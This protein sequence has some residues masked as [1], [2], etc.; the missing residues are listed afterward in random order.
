MV[1]DRP[2][3]ALDNLTR[4]CLLD[5]VQERSRSLNKKALIH[6]MLV[7]GRLVQAQQCQQELADF[8]DQL[9]KKYSGPLQIEAVSGLFLIYASHFVHLLEGPEQALMEFLTSLSDIEKQEDMVGSSKVV[10]IVNDVPT[11]LFSLWNY[12]CV[13]IA[14]LRM[15]ES[16]VQ[17]SVQ[18]KISDSMVLMMK[19][20]QE[21]AKVP[22]LQQKGVLD[23]LVSKHSHLLIHSDLVESLLKST[24]LL[25][26]D[27]YVKMYTKP[28]HVTLDN[29][30][31]WPVKGKPEVL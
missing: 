16:K 8:F 22:K 31:V 5:V 15:D 9:V 14:S 27:E 13:N 7:V 2:D 20:S 23:Q 4:V 19:L 1:D 11:R 10:L 26:A 18:S 21:L 6:R 17:E 24:E 3:S 30:L 25:S 29:E 28:L 12:R